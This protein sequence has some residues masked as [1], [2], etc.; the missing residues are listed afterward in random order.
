MSYDPSHRNAPP[1][2]GRWPYATPAEAWQPYQEDPV[3]QDDA[4]TLEDQRLSRA[5]AGV[6]YRGHGGHGAHGA[7]EG[8]GG[9]VGYQDSFAGSAADRGY[10]GQ[11]QS[12]GPD[13]FAGYP[14]EAYPPQGYQPEGYP[15]EAYPPQGYLTEAYAPEG[16][17]PD[18]YPTEGYPTE[19][20]APDGYPPDGYAPDGYPP[21]GYAPE[22]RAPDG[23]RDTGGGYR[24]GGSGS[25][26]VEG[27][28]GGAGEEFAGPAGYSGRAGYRE[29]GRGGYREPRPSGPLLAA[30]DAGVYPDS[31]QAGRDRRRAARRRGL[32]VGAASGFLATEA[33]IGVSTLAAAFIGRQAAPIIVLGDVFTDRVPAAVRNAVTEHFG[34]NGRAVLLAGMY[35][36]IGLL[37]IAIGLLARRAVAVGVAGLAAFSLL[38]A[39][40]AITRPDG[41]LT[42][43]IPSVVGLLAGAAALV[44][45]IRASAPV[46]PL[47][48]ARGYGRR[49]PR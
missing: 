8:Q 40:V 32:V 42:D 14:P 29:S 7:Y 38:G 3:G 10:H 47:G 27:G 2:Q 21:D 5:P 37:A 11:H 41:R 25:G 24:G 45:L 18:G 4:R 9:Q 17:A 26:L 20:Y 30:P 13:P 19:G 49:R 43:L 1:R 48:K 36:A 33:A 44:W 23:Y 39:F 35:V 31:W 34:M 15:Q 12:R 16:Y 6:G 22:G 46:T 28:R